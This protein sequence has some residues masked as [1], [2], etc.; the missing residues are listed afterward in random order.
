MF[1]ASLWKI[2]IFFYIDFYPTILLNSHISSSS[3]FFVVTIYY[4]KEIG[5]HAVCERRHFYFYF[6]SMD[7]LYVFVLPQSL[8]RI[9]RTVLN[10]NGTSKQP[11]SERG[12]GCLPDARVGEWEG[13]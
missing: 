5:D 7:V 2:V 6:S 8:P 13:G 11:I 12:D 9:L 3:S 10:R 4:S 1:V